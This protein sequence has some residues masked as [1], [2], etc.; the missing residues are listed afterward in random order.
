MFS[1]IVDDYPVWIL[2]GISLVVRVG[3]LLNR[4]DMRPEACVALSGRPDSLMGLMEYERV[5]GQCLYH[6]RTIESSLPLHSNCWIPEILAQLMSSD[7]LDSVDGLEWIQDEAVLFQLT[8]IDFH[9]AIGSQQLPD[10]RIQVVLQ[11][12]LQ[13]IAN[14][15]S[16]LLAQTMFRNL[17][18]FGYFSETFESFNSLFKI[19]IYNRNKT[20]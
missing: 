16:N 12:V 15:S 13:V 19:I 2:F 20:K 14:N 1:G 7:A 4:S 10:T 18:Q 3:L 6:A 17:F 5:I 9:L 11:V 8:A